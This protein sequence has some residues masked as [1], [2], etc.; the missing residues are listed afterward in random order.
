MM[1]EDPARPGADERLR[2]EARHLV[3][4]RMAL[5]TALIWILGTAILFAVIVPYEERP[6]RQVGTAMMLP[7]LPAALPWLFYGYL[8]DRLARRWRNER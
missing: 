4:E 6:F 1:A 8:S 2:R 7:I 3:Y 5:A